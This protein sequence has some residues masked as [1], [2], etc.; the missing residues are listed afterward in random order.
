MPRRDLDAKRAY[1]RQ[2]KRRLTRARRRRAIPTRR[3]SK[4]ESYQRA[5]AEALAQARIRA[6]VYLPPVGMVARTFLNAIY[7]DG[8][9]AGV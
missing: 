9:Q 6:D 5:T 4:S 2:Y 3:A 7:R 1:Q 8:R